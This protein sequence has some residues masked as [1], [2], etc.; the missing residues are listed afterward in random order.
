MISL[1]EGLVILA[2]VGTG[3]VSGL[4]FIFSN[5][6]MT[7]LEQQGADAGAATMVAI[8]EIILNGLFYAVFMVTAVVCVAISVLAVVTGTGGAG[9]LLSA[10]TAYVVG[11]FGVTAAVNVPLN[12]QLAGATLGT[13]EGRAFWRHYLVRW[14]RWNT[15]RTVAGV[16]STV[17]LALSLASS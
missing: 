9:T 3:L 7:A 17:L 10:S 6:I 16:V 11:V 4:L 8:N 15:V 12:N 5:T 13:E 1:M 14:T 2:I